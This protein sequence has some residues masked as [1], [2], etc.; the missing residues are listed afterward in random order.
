MAAIGAAPADATAPRRLIARRRC[1]G[2]PIFARSETAAD[3]GRMKRVILSMSPSSP[4]WSHWIS[5]RFRPRRVFVPWSTQ[6]APCPVTAVVSMSRRS[7][8]AEAKTAMTSSGPS[9]VKPSVSG[10]IRLTAGLSWARISVSS[11]RRSADTQV[12]IDA[13]IPI[14]MS[15]S[16]RMIRG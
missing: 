12:S 6:S 11:C 8:N 7:S 16:V 3:A 1:S 10:E 13:G 15:P 14:T 9:K 5:S 4:T 2:G